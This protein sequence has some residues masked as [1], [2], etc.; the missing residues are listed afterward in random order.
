MSVDDRESQ[1]PDPPAKSGWFGLAASW[2]SPMRV[3]TLVIFLVVVLFTVQLSG[4]ELIIGPV[5]ISPR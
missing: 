4:V 3:G 5:R 2:S 1:E